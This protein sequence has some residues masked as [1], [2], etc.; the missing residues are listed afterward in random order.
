MW[1]WLLLVVHRPSKILAFV[2]P[3]AGKGEAKKILLSVQKIFQR[4][5]V[6]CDSIGELA[7]SKRLPTATDFMQVIQE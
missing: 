6:V 7:F 4:A 1:W 2:N 3:V 5:G